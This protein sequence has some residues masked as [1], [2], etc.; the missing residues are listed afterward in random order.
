MLDLSTEIYAK[1]SSLAKFDKN[2][3]PDETDFIAKRVR[4]KDNKPVPIQ[5]SELAE[6]T[7]AFPLQKINAWRSS[8]KKVLIYLRLSS[9]DI[10]AKIS[11]RKKQN[12]SMTTSQAG[13]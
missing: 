1:I 7:E 10:E 2:F 8:S 12:F 4:T 11:P 5:A 6:A 13:T 9:K 3:G